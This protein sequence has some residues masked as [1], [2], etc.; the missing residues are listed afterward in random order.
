MVI[1]LVTY[2]YVWFFIILCILC[3]FSLCLNKILCL[4]LI[5]FLTQMIDLACVRRFHTKFNLN[6]RNIF[7][8][9]RLNLESQGSI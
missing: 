6:I 1:S 3:I 5:D 7:L 4:S 9:L 2:N 8:N